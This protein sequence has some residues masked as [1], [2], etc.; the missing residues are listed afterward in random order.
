MED[1]ACLEAASA[2]D[3]AAFVRLYEKHISSVYRYAL[4]MLRSVSE[5]EDIAQ[6]VFILAWV[7]RT[8]IR[9]V[10]Q[11]VLPWL[12]VTTRNLSLNRVKRTNRDARKTLK[13]Q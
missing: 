3:S 8:K 9:I 4:Q 1:R 6:E 12:L 10:D 13:A 7:K 2:G 5:A 11:S